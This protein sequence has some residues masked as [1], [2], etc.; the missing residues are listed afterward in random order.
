MNHLDNN[1]FEYLD[2]V[3]EQASL[4]N[5]LELVTDYLTPLEKYTLMSDAVL[6]KNKSVLALFE[7]KPY[8]DQLKEQDF[9]DSRIPGN[10]PYKYY[11]LTNGLQSYV[12]NTFNAEVRLF[13]SV[14]NL[15]KYVSEIPNNQA[16]AQ[17]I[18]SV[19]K[20]IV[21]GVT[22][23][24]EKQN[25]INNKSNQ[26]YS[27]I[28]EYLSY[29]SVAD[30]L[31][32]DQDGQF[33]KLTNDIRDLNNFENG[34]FNLFLDDLRPYSKVYRYTT[35]DTVFAT[36]NH[37]SLRMN[38]IAGMNDISE[39]EYVDQYFDKTFDIYSKPE[40]L[41]IINKRFISCCSTLSD[42]LNQWRL[43][44]DDCKGACLV[45]KV[46]GGSKLPGLQ[47][48]HIN[49]GTK[50]NGANF[51]LELELIKFILEE[52]KSKTG[53]S[54]RFRTLEIWKHFFKPCEYKEEKEVRLLLILNSSSNIKGEGQ[55]LTAHNLQKQWNLTA[56][57]KIL[58]PYITVPLF[59]KT[60][61]IQLEKV[62]L[63]SKCSER[64]LNQQ[65][66][67]LFLAEKKLDNIK[68][69]ISSIHNYR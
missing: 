25:I 67:Q 29:E 46:L 52:V 41:K 15:I 50:R 11:I 13:D 58:A 6:L 10:I 18:D 5:G 43:Y 20:A 51:H 30:N 48:K 36:L 62:V 31:I 16:I 37:L 27:R 38:G 44:G 8:Q 47:L 59:D 49:Y 28:K 1:I 24:Y 34:L 68:I 57:H 12:L 2:Q 55:D 64:I 42:N 35:L 4:I 69:E 17:N 33:F 54:L 14:G 63:G 61:P 53:Q 26:K 45:F 66:L 23:F 9:L 19:A 3:K 32:F 40:E 65:Q 21:N 39:V 56:S 7:F 60:L 22:S